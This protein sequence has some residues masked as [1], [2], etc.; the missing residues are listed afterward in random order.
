MST[1]KVVYT[2]QA[3][4]DL[5]EIYEYIA[6]PLL[7]PEIGKNQ[8]RRIMVAVAGL[9][10]MPLRHRLYDKEPWYSKGLR[11]LPID[12]YLA[13]YLPVE[14]HKTVAVIRIMYGGRSIEAQLRLTDT[15]QCAD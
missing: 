3:E 4:Q 15:D 14:T 8:I 9:N 1:W 12:N 13:F 7:E 2:E 6:F 5:R 11:V 10:Q